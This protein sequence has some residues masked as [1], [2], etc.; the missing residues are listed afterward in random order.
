MAQAPELVHGARAAA[1]RQRIG[2]LP[3]SAA[4]R[5]VQAGLAEAHRTVAHAGSR[6]ADLIVVDC[7][8]V[9]VA[10]ARGEAR[11]GDL[12]AGVAADPVLDRIAID[13]IANGQ[14]RW[15]RSTLG[16]RQERT[17]HQGGKG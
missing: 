1:G 8:A 16:A 9:V 4:K 6:A 10:A 2:G 12:E 11:Q 15:R 7:G 3:L 17:Q 5:I 14:I 13:D